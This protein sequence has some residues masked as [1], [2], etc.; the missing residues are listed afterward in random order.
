[1]NFAEI[2]K[3]MGKDPRDAAIDLVIADKAESSVIISIM[4]EDD[5]RRGDADAVGVVRH[6]LGRPR[7]G[8]AAVGIEVASAR[9]GHLHR[10]CSAS[11][12]ATTRVLTLEE[13]VRK[14]PPRRRRSASASPT[15]ACCGPA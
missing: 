6:R 11:T 3:A 10:A 15:V 7:R 4:R 1:M 5:V 2:G 13:A 9:L 8:R 14:M 12:C